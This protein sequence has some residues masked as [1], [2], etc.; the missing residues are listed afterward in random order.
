MKNKFRE[1]DVN[2][3]ESKGKKFKLQMK[4]KKEKKERMT[5]DKLSSSGKK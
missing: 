1:K 3:S 5:D 4:P 2:F